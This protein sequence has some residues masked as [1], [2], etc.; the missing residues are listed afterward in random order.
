MPILKPHHH[1]SVLNA[2]PGTRR[3]IAD[4]TGLSPDVVR[5][6]TVALLAQRKAHVSG[7]VAP[8][9]GGN[10][11]PIWSQGRAMGFI[12]P[13]PALKE[14]PDDDREHRKA[15]RHVHR[16]IAALMA[17]PKASIFSPLGMT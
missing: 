7:S 15:L 13:A 9:H 5:N 12:P 16:H 11:I 1:S 4:K 17:G 8:A 14:T 6:S 3:E 10:P 2:M